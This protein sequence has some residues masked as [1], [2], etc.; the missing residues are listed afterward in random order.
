MLHLSFLSPSSSTASRA[1]R[2]IIPRPLSLPRL[3]L[4]ICVVLGGA[5]S[6][7]DARAQLSVPGILAAGSINGPTA[8]YLRLETIFPLDRHIRFVAEDYRR[9]YNAI[10]EQAKKKETR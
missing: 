8:T 10:V 9:A 1:S 6:F 2:S 4:A 5:Y 7:A 3:F